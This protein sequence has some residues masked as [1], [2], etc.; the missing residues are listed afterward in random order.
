ML[1]EDGFWWKDYM[2]LFFFNRKTEKLEIEDFPYMQEEVKEMLKYYKKH[3]D[4]LEYRT[5]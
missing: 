5:D 3:G 4:K 2:R 1:E